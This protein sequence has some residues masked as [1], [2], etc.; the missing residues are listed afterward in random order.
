MLL[1]KIGNVTRYD[2]KQDRTDLMENWEL[3]ITPNE[4]GYKTLDYKGPTNHDKTN[5][6]EEEI[7]NSTELIQ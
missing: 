5:V 4:T 7:I 1:Q 2:T 6:P 3:E